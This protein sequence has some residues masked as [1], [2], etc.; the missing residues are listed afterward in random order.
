ML[1]LTDQVAARRAV[2]AADPPDW[3]VHLT[4]RLA[5]HPRR[6]DVVDAVIVWRGVS[7]QTDAA[8]AFGKEPNYRDY[9]RPYWDRLQSLVD[10]P[11]PLEIADDDNTAAGLTP[12]PIDWESVAAEPAFDAL[13]DCRSGPAQPVPS[14][15]TPPS[16]ETHSPNPNGPS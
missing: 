14:S 9:L 5:S 13:D 11:A 4:Q 15:T 3:F 8:T 16:S 2:L 6:D 12:D 10:E 1:A 7:D